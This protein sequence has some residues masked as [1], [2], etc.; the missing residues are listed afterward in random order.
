MESQHL[1]QRLETHAHVRK[2]SY[3]NIPKH[4]QDK[5]KTVFLKEGRKGREENRYFLFNEA[6]TLI[7]AEGHQESNSRITKTNNK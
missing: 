4:P 6:I 7:T 1:L 5:A 2:D 3:Q